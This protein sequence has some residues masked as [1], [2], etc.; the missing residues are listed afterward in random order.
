M[1][2]IHIVLYRNFASRLGF[3]PTTICMVQDFVIAPQIEY[4]A[5]HIIQRFHTP[6]NIRIVCVHNNIPYT[7][8]VEIFK[9]LF[10]G[11]GSRPC[12]KIKILKNFTS[13]RKIMVHSTVD[14][15]I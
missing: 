13:I 10:R 8:T 6:S 15:G 3:A 9:G 14:A 11:K 7:S 1:T 12:V 5:N 4:I 2:K